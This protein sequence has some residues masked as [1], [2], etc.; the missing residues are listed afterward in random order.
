MDKTI[1]AWINQE[2]VYGLTNFMHD[3]PRR[4]LGPHIVDEQVNINVYYPDAVSIN[5][6]NDKNGKVFPMT[7]IL[8]PGFFTVETQ[9]KKAFSYTVEAIFAD[10]NTY[11][12]KD[13]YA[14][15]QNLKEEDIEKFE[16]G[17]HYT[18]Y[19]K[20][21]AHKIKQHGTTGICFAVWAPTAT[22][23]SVVGDFNNWDGRRHMMCKL[24]NSGIFE[25]FIPNLEEGALYK[26]E[27]RA[28]N[29][30]VFLKTDPYGNFCELRPNTA[31]IVTDIDSYKWNDQKWLKERKKADTLHKPMSIY[32]VHLG[33]WKTPDDG[34][35]YY[36]YRE[37]APMLADYVLDMGYT[38]I[39]LMPVT[40]YP[41]DPSWG[42]Q[43]SCYYAPTSRYG[44]PQDFMYFVD[45]MHQKGI[46]IIM[47]W[48]PAHFPK[49]ATGL[50]RFDGTAL[51]EHLDPRQGEHPDWGTYIFNY[52][53]P[54][55]KNFLIANALF[56]IHK[57]HIDGIRMDAV[58]SMLYLDYGRE[59]GQWVANEY[60]GHENLEALEFLKHLNSIVKGE[61]SGA[62]MIAEEST[63][64]PYLTHDLQSNDQAVGFD[65]KWNMGWMND[66]LDYMKTDPLFRKGH[67]GQLTFS[68]MYAYSEH[69][70]LVLSHDEVVHMKGSMIGKMPGEY[71]DKFNNL[72]VAYGFMQ[73]HPGKKLLFMGQEFA[74]F[75]EFNEAKQLDWNLVQDFEKHQQMQLYVKDLNK[76][77]KSEP[78][79]YELDVEPEGFEWMSC[80]NADDSIVSF[81]RR[82]KKADE[83]LFIVCNFTPVAREEYHLGVPFAGTYK[84]I[85][86]SD[87]VKY[88]GSGHL[89]PRS[90]RSKKFE[91]DGKE[92]S[93]QVTVPPLGISVY[94]CKMAKPKKTTSKTT[95]KKAKKTS[96]KK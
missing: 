78:A 12:Y 73:A 62:I 87:D 47:D 65:F 49:D 35:E 34:R 71:D 6:I 58:A 20:L 21:G 53:R 96:K 4:L 15:E 14:F 16:Q 51:Y 84:E 57:Y 93:I 9:V 11:R 42:Y 85:F 30:D 89:N 2:E 67:H 69:Y 41:F 13:P 72:R 48:V 64:W 7:N 44:E 86:N 95:T 75:S 3:N 17:I 70:V 83:T 1:G 45:Y 76:L 26:F 33:G 29:G 22:R 38:H 50:G 25:L 37:I 91:W 19:D 55:V 54:E 23:V 32:E 24:P 40:E 5:I 90:K 28:Q 80:D 63:A 56:W 81:V 60:G 43:V 77:Y 68:M 94:R 92:N 27:I 61:H 10:G 39:E 79:F 18:I 82:S 52:G 59:D 36:N 31:S 74:Q 8:A 66:F 88:G 46:S